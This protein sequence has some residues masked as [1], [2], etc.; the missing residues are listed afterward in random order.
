MA[1]IIVVEDDLA[2]QEEILSFL[3]H[4]G[5]EVSGVA[6]G[7]ALD[8]CL[9]SFSPEIILLDYNL[10]DENGPM[11]AER[12]RARF[13]LALGIVMITARSLSADRVE[14]RRAGADDYLVKPIEFNEMLA[15]IDNLLLRI[16][17]AALAAQ[18]WKLIPEQAELLPPDGVPVLLVDSEVLL[19][20]ALAEGESCKASREELIRA[21]G[22]NPDYYDQRALETAISRLRRKLPTLEDGRSP[23]QTMRGNGYQFIRPLRIIT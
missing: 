2:Q 22:K 23:L 6:S 20:T 1:R 13:G 14:C 16:E 8:L 10:P 3:A 17:P 18:T 11:L 4:T 21:L 19:L 12:L 7:C 5:H 15:V 9:D